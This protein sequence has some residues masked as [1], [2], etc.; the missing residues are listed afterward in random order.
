MR[1][2]P[3]RPSCLLA[4]CPH[5]RG[6]GALLC[7]GNLHYNPFVRSRSRSFHSAACC[8]AFL[9]VI[10]GFCHAQQAPAPSGARILLLP[11]KLVTGEHA[12]L[13][14]LDVAGRLTPAV[15]VDFS[16]GESVTTD[17]TGR[18]LFV[19]PLNPGIIHAS[20]VGRPGRVSSA[21][22]TLADVPSGTEAVTAAPRV[23]SVSDRFELLGHGFCGDADANHVT[24]AGLPG[25]V[26]ASSPASLT[27]LP[28]TSMDPGPA[29]V[30]V[31]CGQKSGAPFIIVFVRLELEASDAPLAPG[32]H[33]T[34][35]VHVHGSTAK[36]NLEARNLSPEVAELLGG[37]KVRALSSGGAENVAKFELAGKQ[38]GNFIVSIR[39]LAPLS[40]PR[41]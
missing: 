19:A 23:A 13:A 10:T 39:L 21:V 14:V 4:H 26:L 11:R 34:L 15:K 29:E 5:P 30:N 36:I 41:P 24:I 9:F 18:A 35:T 38:R 17:A 16:D 32:E 31:A 33:R 40:A 28:P 12:T 37:E 22:L 3:S 20:I 7:R 2:T 1:K 27:V 8:L 25:L 6:Q